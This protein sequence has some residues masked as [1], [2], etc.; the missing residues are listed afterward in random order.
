MPTSVARAATRSTVWSSRIPKASS[1]SA[2][3]LDDDAARFPC[4]TTVVPVPATTRAAIVET[5]TV[6]IRSPPVPTRS[7]LGPGTS[8]RTACASIVSASAVSSTTDSPF[9]R[10][11]TSSPATRTGETSPDMI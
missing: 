11:A 2:D 10:R 9:A 4:F 8:K 5:L 7:M 6:C 3:P 1:T